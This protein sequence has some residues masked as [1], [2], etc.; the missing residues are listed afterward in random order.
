MNNSD[1]FAYC[2]DEELVRSVLPDWPADLSLLLCLKAD[3]TCRTVIFHVEEGSRALRRAA[4]AMDLPT[5]SFPVAPEVK[6]WPTRV[7]RF[8]E[9]QDMLTIVAGVSGLA[10]KARIYAQEYQADKDAAKAPKAVTEG[11]E[12]PPLKEKIQAGPTRR[13]NLGLAKADIAEKVRRMAAEVPPP[14]SAPQMPAGFLPGGAQRECQFGA[15]HIGIAGGYVRIVLSP[16]RVT[17]HTGP[18]VV[19]EIGFSADFWRFYLPRSALRGWVPGKAAVLDVPIESFPE[20]LRRAFE[21]RLYHVEA[22]ITSE[23]VFLAPGGPVATEEVRTEPVPQP[24]IRSRRRWLTPLRAA[25]AACVVAGTA[26]AAVN[27]VPF[28]PVGTLE[29]ILASNSE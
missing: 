29:R 21:G 20:A 6:G 25:A 9:E 4:A 2:F 17:V 5:R 8:S 12:A 16:D 13:L 11:A 23:G 15:G 28:G 27:M 24:V 7:V 18:E 1:A 22:T 26:A 3:G 19:T 10:E 14:P